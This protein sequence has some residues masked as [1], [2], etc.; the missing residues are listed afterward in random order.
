MNAHTVSPD[1]GWHWGV[2]PWFCLL[3][4]QS[5]FGDAGQTETEKKICL[6]NWMGRQT[7]RIDGGSNTY[8][9]NEPRGFSKEGKDGGPNIYPQKGR[10]GL[11]KE[12]N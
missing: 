1:K 5:L 11:S 8:L 12:G 7:Q 4:G 2:E 3:G 9:P 6:P 10:R